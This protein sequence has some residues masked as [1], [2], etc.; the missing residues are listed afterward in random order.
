MSNKF[1]QPCVFAKRKGRTTAAPKPVPIEQSLDAMKQTATRQLG[2]PSSTPVLAIY[3]EDDTLITDVKQI[4]AGMTIFCSTIEPQD[5]GEARKSPQRRASNRPVYVMPN[6]VHGPG[7]EMGAQ[8]DQHETLWRRCGA[9]PSPC[10][11]S[12][13]TNAKHHRMTNATRQFRST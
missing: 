6:V 2:Y 7:Y 13:Y 9:T 8:L 3:D 1:A 12:W 10:P 5:D 4:K 11:P